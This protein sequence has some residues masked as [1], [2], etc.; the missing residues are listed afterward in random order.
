MP[1]RQ[2]IL[3]CQSC[4]PFVSMSPAQTT[5]KPNSLWATRWEKVYPDGGG[6]LCLVFPSGEMTKTLPPESDFVKQI[7]QFE[8]MSNNDCTMPGALNITQ[9]PFASH[10]ICWPN[11]FSLNFETKIFKLSPD[12]EWVSLVGLRIANRLSLL[13]SST[14][15]NNHAPSGLASRT[16][17][18]AAAL[19]SLTPAKKRLSHCWHA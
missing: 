5:H 17:G 13:Q 3:K 18:R 7:A 6:I 4:H 12:I 15:F 1:Q 19:P 14:E 9:A 11:R 16:G 2:S 8:L 10:V